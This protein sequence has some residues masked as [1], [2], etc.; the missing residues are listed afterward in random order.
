M[1]SAVTPFDQLL[2]FQHYCFVQLLVT[3]CRLQRSTGPTRY[4]VRRLAALT[5]PHMPITYALVATT[6]YASVASLT[7]SFA[8]ID[9]VLESM[10]PAARSNLCHAVAARQRSVCESD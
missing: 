6:V 2:C 10:C 5:P 7:V 4:C 1:S 9:H 3:H 8:H